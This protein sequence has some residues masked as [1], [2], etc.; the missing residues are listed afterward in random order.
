M[1]EA[2]AVVGAVASTVQLIDFS[3]K[4]FDRLNDYIRHIDQVPETL[5]EIK[6]QLALLIETLQRVQTNIDFGHFNPR[7]SSVMKD[8]VDEIYSQMILLDN[9]LLRVTP[10]EGDSMIKRGQKAILS[11]K[12]E[13]TLKKIFERIS[14]YV[15]K[16][17]L[18]RTSIVSTRAM[19]HTE[20]LLKMHQNHMACGSLVATSPIT[21]ETLVM[22]NTSEPVE[23]LNADARLKSIANYSKRSKDRRLSYFLS[24]SR[25]GLL[26]AL[27]V[28]LNI[29]WGNK[30]MSIIPGLHFQQLVK[31]NSPGL[32][33][34]MEFM[35]GQIDTKSAFQALVGLFRRGVVSPYDIF[36]D[37]RTW[38]EKILTH[39]PIYVSD[40]RRIIS[41]LRVLCQCGAWMGTQI[42][43]LFI[44]A[45]WRG[46]EH[47]GNHLSFL[48]ELIAMGYDCSKDTS[49]C[50][51]AYN[52]LHVG[53]Y[54]GMDTFLLKFLAEGSKN[55]C[56]EIRTF[57]QDPRSLQGTNL[58]G[59]SP[60]HVA[61][62]RPA[63]LSIIVRV[64]G[65]LDMP[66][67]G[68]KTPLEYAAAYGSTESMLILLESGANPVRGQHIP[69]LQIALVKGHWELFSDAVVFFRKQ[70]TFSESFL[71]DQLKHLMN[72]AL[73]LR[74]LG[75]KGFCT[76][77]GLGIDMRTVSEDGNTLLH[78]AESAENVAALFSTA[79]EFIDDPNDHG[80]TAL[81]TSIEKKKL[82]VSKAI[83][84]KGCNINHQDNMGLSALHIASKV[85]AKWL[86]W[87]LTLSELRGQVIGRK[88][89]L[90]LIR[91]KEF[92]RA[93]LTHVCT[94]NHH[95]NFRVY[96]DEDEID[97]IL[98]EEKE[99]IWQ[100]EV[101]MEEWKRKLDDFPVEETWLGMLNEFCPVNYKPPPS[102]D[103]LIKFDQFIIHR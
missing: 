49:L 72:E 101:T 79:S 68:G 89:L 92:Q 65:D 75:S 37:G 3:A 38:L 32:G 77:L 19:I 87:L 11:L 23:N 81:M 102:Q 94:A 93:E 51:S 88:A 69:F 100:L 20:S 21:T 13:S 99:T 4:V 25:F 103:H 85:M 46:S 35:M 74:V 47:S 45:R 42:P 78:F 29:S 73:N 57:V 54:V 44:T 66:D 39:H 98:D 22:G 2:F 10:G 14:R 52:D 33:I 18:L 1:A 60:V 26:W 27:Q 15:E 58:L 5:R 63:A 7:T 34:F 48:R 71:Q 30:G 90:D 86:T 31:N 80:R 8:L 16:L 17:L 97:E 64:F 40:P 6:L 43:L 28:D 56:D 41:M 84:Q 59:Q 83:V 62:L 95:S 12:E 53:S 70:R 76:F 50:S 96:L 55:A 82:E 91:L 24:L 61:V 9:L 36:P 67:L